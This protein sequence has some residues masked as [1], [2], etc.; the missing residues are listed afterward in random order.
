MKASNT[1]NHQL[2][3]CCFCFGVGPNWCRNGCSYCFY[4][5]REGSCPLNIWRDIHAE[6]LNCTSA[7]HDH[8]PFMYTERKWMVPFSIFQAMTQQLLAWYV[9][10]HLPCPACLWKMKSSTPD[11]IEN[12]RPKAQIFGCYLHSVVLNYFD[13]RWML[14]N[15]SLHVCLLLRDYLNGK[16][17]PTFDSVSRIQIKLFLGITHLKFKSSPLKIYHPKRQRIVFQ[18]H[19]FWGGRTVKLWGCFRINLEGFP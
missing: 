19:H 12:K 18:S 10:Y 15:D 13:N 14:L 4:S 8:F 16:P 2:K 1:W 17:N 6:T 9:F 11:T 3:T 5:Y 7:P